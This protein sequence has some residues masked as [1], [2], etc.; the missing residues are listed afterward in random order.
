MGVPYMSEWETETWNQMFVYPDRNSTPPKPT[1]MIMYHFHKYTDYTPYTSGIDEHL[2]FATPLGGSSETKNPYTEWADMNAVVGAAPIWTN[3]WRSESSAGGGGPAFGCPT[4]ETSFQ[5]VAYRGQDLRSEHYRWVMWR[6]VMH[7]GLIY[8]S[9]RWIQV[10]DRCK[11]DYKKCPPFDPLKKGFF[12]TERDPK[13]S[14]RMFV[15]GL[16]TV[17]IS[18]TI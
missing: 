5:L 11:D 4:M 6:E 1:H 17:H 16:M 15:K 9:V 8:A 2:L 7:D 14:T 12:G 13:Y 3:H 18:R 10:T